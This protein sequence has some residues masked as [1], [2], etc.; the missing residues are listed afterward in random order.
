MSERTYSIKEH[1]VEDQ[2]KRASFFHLAGYYIDVRASGWLVKTKE[3]KILKKVVK[4]PGDT[5]LQHDDLRSRGYD[6][7]QEALIFCDEHLTMR[8]KLRHMAKIR[9]YR[10]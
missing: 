1:H 4:I 10:S 9:G 2:K 8:Q 6:N 7:M 3:G 5:V